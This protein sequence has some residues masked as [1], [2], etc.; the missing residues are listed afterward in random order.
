[1]VL[2]IT[3]SWKHIGKILRGGI[4]FEKAK[5]SAYNISSGR[6]RISKSEMMFKDL[7]DWWT[8]I[9]FSYLPPK[10]GELPYQTLFSTKVKSNF[11][12]NPLGL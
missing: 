10:K 5:N 4:G 3:G 1:M 11:L 9:S 7:L 12:K 8:C 2:P 6:N